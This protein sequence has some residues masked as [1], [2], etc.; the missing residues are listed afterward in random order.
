[1]EENNYYNLHFE[2][3]MM[4]PKLTPSQKMAGPISQVLEAYEVW[5]NERGSLM[6]IDRA[7]KDRLLNLLSSQAAHS[8]AT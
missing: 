4:P 3:A 7:N 6:V 8:A 5:S 1:M 2:I